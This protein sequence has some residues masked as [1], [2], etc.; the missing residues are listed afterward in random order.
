MAT[1]IDRRPGTATSATASGPD[2][3]VVARI[4]N[5][6]VGV[7]LFI[8]AFIWPHSASSRMNT[9]IVGALC[10][11][12]AV[13]ALKSPPVRWV[14]AV[15]SVWLFFSALS[16]YHLSGGTY[17]NN[18]IAAIVMFIASLVPSRAVSGVG[19]PP[20]YATP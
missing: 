9:W 6:I 1:T 20:R 14:N 12:F 7:W 19:R 3:G 4:A 8:S 15:L 11:I 17:W 16:I 2:S 13:I 10:A 5:I 18:L